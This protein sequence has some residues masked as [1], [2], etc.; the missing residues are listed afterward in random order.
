MVAVRVDPNSRPKEALEAMRAIDAMRRPGELMLL[1]ALLGLYATIYGFALSDFYGPINVAGPI[2][3]AAILG[4][5]CYQIVRQSPVAVWA[6]LFWFRLAC[7]V[8]FGFGALVPHIVNEE[9]RSWIFSL[10]RFDDYINTKVNFI[11]ALG[12]WLTLAFSA[13]FLRPRRALANSESLASGGPAAKDATLLFAI[14]LLV[15]GGLLRYGL[16]LPYTYGLLEVT[17]PG[18]LVTLSKMYYAGVFLLIKHGLSV[19]RRVFSIAIP[20][21]LLDLVISIAAFAKTEILVMLI[22]VFLGLISRGASMKKIIFGA[23]FVMAVFVGSQPLVSY[24]R[25]QLFLRY[26]EIRG[27]GLGERVA[28]VQDFLTTGGGSVSAG[29]QG[30]LSRLSYVNA[31]AFVVNQFDAGRPGNTLRHA[32]AVLVPRALWPEKPVI[33]QLGVD[34]NIL[35]F[36]RDGSQVG[37]GHFAEAYWNYGWWGMPPFMA[38]LALILSVFSRFSLTVMAYRKWLFLPV[39]FIGVNM[40]LRVDGHFVA[41]IVGPFWMALCLAFASMAMSVIIGRMRYQGRL[42]SSRHFGR[43]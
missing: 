26:G 37:V 35:I 42:S 2:G 31:N 24:G 14:C 8:Y 33:T 28:I 29:R 30:G 13:L 6:P 19:D 16:V 34:L 18:A 36:G 25:D 1:G 9:T 27:A 11:Y 20:V 4:W 3:L 32:A 17:V 22:F 40:G 39:V 38:V 21:V 41:D 12:V 15:L 23:I 10:Y 7:G 43:S 5:S